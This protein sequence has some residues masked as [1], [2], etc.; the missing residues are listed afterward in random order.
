MLEIV[1]DSEPTN[2]GEDIANG[3]LS[4]AAEALDDW[5]Y[6]ALD[7]AKDSQDY[8]NMNE[9]AKANFDIKQKEIKE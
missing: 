2:A 3:A 8:E 1:D 4:E 9:E 5:Y 6:N 7:D